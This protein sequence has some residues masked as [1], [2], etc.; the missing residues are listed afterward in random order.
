[1]V[2]C[3]ECKLSFSKMSN[4]RA[5]VK[6]KHPGKIDILAP[7]LKGRHGTLIC[8]GCRATFVRIGSL[9][10]HVRRKHADKLQELVPAKKT[11]NCKQCNS[12]FDMLKKLVLHRR[13][14]HEIRNKM[15]KCPLCQFTGPSSKH[16]I[17]HYRTGHSLTVDCE[18]VEFKT[19][20]EFQD[21]K[22]TTE[23]QT[24]SS[25]VNMH[26][27]RKGVNCEKIKY[28]CHRSGT[29]RKR[30]NNIRS[31]K[32]NKMNGYCPAEMWV[33]IEPTKCA[34]KFCN[35]HVGHKLEENIGRNKKYITKENFITDVHEGMEDTVMAASPEEENLQLLFE[36]QALAETVQKLLFSV[37]TLEEIEAV[38]KIVSRI[39]PALEQIRNS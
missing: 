36:K 30:G 21:W 9:R 11:F 27:F 38:K 17:G 34:V 23:K 6:K 4:L 13:S 20:E 39:Q 29:I 2:Y 8:Q 22:I 26:G 37:E 35:T 3:A 25:F 7:K 18:T 24:F 14:Q 1:M 31:R 12:E 28:T 10:T 5:H 16:L 33:T 19:F 15:L 32:S